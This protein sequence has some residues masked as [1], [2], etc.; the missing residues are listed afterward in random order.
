R[1]V[2]CQ[3]PPGCR[4]VALREVDGMP[5]PAYPALPQQFLWLAIPAICPPGEGMFVWDGLRLLM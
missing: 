5:H 3:R 2:R 1:R 4:V